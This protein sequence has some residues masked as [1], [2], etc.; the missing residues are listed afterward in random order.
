MAFIKLTDK[1]GSMEVVVFPKSF[2]KYKEILVADTCIAVKGKIS[3]RNGEKSM[4]AEI[5]KKVT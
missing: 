2:E 4:L 1:S 5:I 3:E